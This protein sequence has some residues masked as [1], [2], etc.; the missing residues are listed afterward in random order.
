ME[1][2]KRHM[3]D[4]G[5]LAGL[6]SPRRARLGTHIVE[7]CVLLVRGGAGSNR[8]LR[9]STGLELS[10]YIACIVGVRI[11]SFLNITAVIVWTGSSIL[12]WGVVVSVSGLVVTIHVPGARGCIG[13]HGVHLVDM[14]RVHTGWDGSSTTSQLQALCHHF[15]KLLSCQ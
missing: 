9:S 11:E 4:T 14:G 13:I 1:E 7:P 10:R 3:G 5:A 8:R 15:M 12:A 6:L 2:A